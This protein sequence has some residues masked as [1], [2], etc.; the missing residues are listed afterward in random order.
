MIAY[1]FSNPLFF[2][3]W[4]IALV[5]AVTVHEFA[6]AFVSDRL[7]DPTAKLSGRVTLNPLSHLDPVGTIAILI[8]GF[9]WGKPV[10]FD[11]FNLANPRRDASLISLA[12]PASN[13]IVVV[14]LALTAQLLPGMLFILIPIITVNLM[15]GVFNLIPIHPLDGAK[16]VAGFLPEDQAHDWMLVQERYGMLFLLAILLPITPKGS[17]V[18][19]TIAP[20]LDFVLKLLLG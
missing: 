11:P 19:Q 14:I 13:F 10:P 20:L 17:L 18:S 5:I 1:L 2:V 9:G 12:G 6:H 8:A 16:I 7:G 15:L 3:L 4:A